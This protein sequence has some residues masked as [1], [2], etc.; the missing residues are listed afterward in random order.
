[1]SATSGDVGAGTGEPTGQVS[2]GPAGLRVVIIPVL[3]DNYAYLLVDDEKREA[4]AVD[5]VEAATVVARAAQEGISIVGILTT[6]KH[7][8]HAGGNN[9]MVA[10]IPGLRVFGGRLDAV[11]GCTDPLDDG[12]EL[13]L[14]SIQIRAIH[15]PG[16]TRGS[17][18]YYCM[19]GESKAVFTGDTLFVGGCGRVFE[20]TPEDLY[21]SLAN[22]LG[23]LPLDTQVYVGHEY[24]VKNLQ[25]AATQEPGNEDLR[26]WL[27]WSMDQTVER[28]FTVPSTMA[29]EW[30]MNPFLRTESAEIKAA[31]PGCT[32]PAL[33]FATLRE[34]K[35]AF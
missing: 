33:V 3:S 32:A 2:S 14:G 28:K 24:T 13:S 16:H 34:R 10:K 35:N 15:T 21:D 18:S 6:H 9:D 30:K 27:K 12:A 20:C 22:K 26:Q 25:F 19:R 1:M 31:C 4:L 7:W 29:A 23:R 5:P 8:D 11:E 17:V